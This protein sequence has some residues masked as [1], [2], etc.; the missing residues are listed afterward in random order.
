MDRSPPS[1]PASNAT[2]SQRN[3]TRRALAVGSRDELLA[4][5]CCS[6][7]APQPVGSTTPRAARGRG[8]PPRQVS[9]A[10]PSLWFAGRALMPRLTFP[11]SHLAFFP[12]FADR[13]GLG[14]GLG[15]G[16]ARLNRITSGGGH[17]AWPEPLPAPGPNGV[18][19]GRGGRA[20]RAPLRKQA[21]RDRRH[22]AQAR[23]ASR[24]A[25]GGDH[26]RHAS[27][28]GR[29]GRA[30]GGW[31]GGGGQRAGS[32]LASAA[33]ARPGSARLGGVRRDEMMRGGLD[34]S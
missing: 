5:G 18:G 19:G 32:A 34:G 9:Q 1:A 17:Q 30:R 23:P 16:R 6:A 14:L 7:P 25:G 31:E 11:R 15:L 33:A 13:L 26:V 29:T 10:S 20:R 3:P 4:A 21:E 24:K 2:R 28:R 12:F 27:R 22:D 8:R